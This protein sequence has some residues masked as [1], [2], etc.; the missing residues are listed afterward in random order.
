VLNAVAALPAPLPLPALPALELWVLD[1]ALPGVEVLVLDPEERS[2]AARMGGEDRAAFV[3][4]HVLLR[5]LL[6]DRLGVAPQDIAYRREPCPRCGALRGRPALASPHRS[7]HFSLSRRAGMILIGIASAPVGVDVEAL[8]ARATA[9]EVAEL[10]H[11][12]ERAEIFAVAPATRAEAF[13]RVW[14]RKE[15][16]LKAVGTG[17]GHGLEQDYLGAEGRAPAPEDFTI[18][19][20]PVAAGY[21]AAVA[22]RGASTP[23]R[24][25]TG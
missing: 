3:T 8:P 14:T 15:A 11:P 24:A 9:T 19:D 22:V 23:R 20:V 1:A 13:A 4:A 5:R 18:A 7:L 25:R 21:R 12:E 17:A 2:R 6:A 16:Y 10:L